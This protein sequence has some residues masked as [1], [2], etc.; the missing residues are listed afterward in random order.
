RGYN[1]AELLARAFVRIQGL[2]LRTD[3][4]E[5]TRA[6][7]AQTHLVA[8]ERRRNV[9]SA[10]ALVSPAAAVNGRRILLID[11]VTTTGST[12]DAAAE[13]L[14]AAGA[15]SLWGLAFARPA[16]GASDTNGAP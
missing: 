1:Q 5:R 3:I 9:A 13:P 15:A 11:D 14:R 12:L 16:L 4:L 10:F 6:T 8:E 2:P 7:E